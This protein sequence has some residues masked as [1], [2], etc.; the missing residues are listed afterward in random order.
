MN[1]QN[2]LQDTKAS[3]KLIDWR[4]YR[5]QGRANET[6]FRAAGKRKKAKEEYMNTGENTEKTENQNPR[7]TM[8]AV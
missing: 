8:T 4:R 1:K 3:R 2:R 5:Q 6:Q 7:N